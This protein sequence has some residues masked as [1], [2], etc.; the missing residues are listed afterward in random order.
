MILFMGQERV[1][2]GNGRVFDITHEINPNTPTWES[3]NGLGHYI[4]IVAG[5]QLF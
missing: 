5:Q 2:R 3:K 1:L 4:R